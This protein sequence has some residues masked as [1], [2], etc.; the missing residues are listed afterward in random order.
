[1]FMNRYCLTTSLENFKPSGV[2][3]NAQAKIHATGNQ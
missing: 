1:L 3:S 2:N